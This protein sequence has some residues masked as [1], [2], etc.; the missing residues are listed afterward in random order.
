M[1]IW[2]IALCNTPMADMEVVLG[3]VIGFSIAGYLI[4]AWNKVKEKHGVK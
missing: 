1:V 2:I 4:Y 3:Q